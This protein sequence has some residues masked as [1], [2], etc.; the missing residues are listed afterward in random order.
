E[1]TSWVRIPPSARR[2]SD[3]ARDL[4][5]VESRIAREQLRVV[6]VAEVDEHDRRRAAVRK[7]LRVDHR[8]VEA[9]HRAGV[10]PQCA[11]R[12]DEVAAL[13]RRVHE[14]ELARRRDLVL[15]AET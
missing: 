10:E 11:R 15:A 6:T 5:D 9:A 2:A 12:D 8:L 13:Q 4:V 1:S 3:E 7:E 14:R